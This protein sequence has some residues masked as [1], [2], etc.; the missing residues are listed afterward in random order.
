M[1]TFAWFDVPMHIFAIIPV[2]LFW[3]LFDWHCQKLTGSGAATID[4]DQK[5]ATIRNS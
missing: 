4:L 3:F 5:K 2:C 1:T